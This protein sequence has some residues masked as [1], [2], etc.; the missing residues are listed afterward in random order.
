MRIHVT[1]ASGSGTSTLAAALA[2]E[3]RGVHLDA[4]DYYWLPGPPRFTHK[5]AAP[6]RLSMLLADLAAEE[7]AILAGSVVGWGTELEDSFDLIVFLYLDAQV[8]VERLREREIECLGHADPA[9]L[10]WAAQYDEGPAQGRSLAKHRAW[11]AARTCPVVEIHGDL[12]VDERLA[13]VRRGAA[14]C[15]A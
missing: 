11:L 10:A 2:Q 13:A 8:R 1:G 15:Q 5:R 3:R 14:G 4:D 9:F 12:T 6:E 7:R